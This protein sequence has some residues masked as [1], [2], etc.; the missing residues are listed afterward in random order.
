MEKIKQKDGSFRYREMFW[1]NGQ[2]IKSPVFKRKTDCIEWITKQKANK[3]LN[4]V[5]GQQR[6][7][8]EKMSL[9]NYCD[10]WLEAKVA[11]GAARSTLKNYESYVRVHIKP[12]FKNRDIKEVQKIDIQ[13]FQIEL[14]KNHNAKGTNLVVG[15][16][17]SIFREAVKDDYLLKSPC[18][19]IKALKQDPKVDKFWTTEEIRHFLNI[20]YDHELYEL[21]LIAMNTGMRRGE[22]AGLCW[23]RV[24]FEKRTILISRTRDHIELKDRPKNGRNRIIVMN[25]EVFMTLMNLKKKNID[26]KFVFNTRKGHPIDPN[27][28]YRDFTEAQIKAGMKTLLRFHDLRHTYASAFVNSGRSIYSLQKLLGHT[29]IKM[30]QRYAHHSIE[31]LH[32]SMKGF[33]L[34]SVKTAEIAANEIKNVIDF[35]TIKIEEANQNLT[36]LDSENKKI[37]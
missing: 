20:N 3:V 37:K 13:R 2:P 23:D 29:D 27:H 30:T 28:I 6:K 22:L 5:H 36:I 8:I 4:Q 9:A 33:S 11:Q 16:L 18:E 7:L 14:R 10:F 21:F 12:F 35:R 17:K 32:E 19:Y 24:D 31:A 34:G 1:H 25:D 26:S 15:A